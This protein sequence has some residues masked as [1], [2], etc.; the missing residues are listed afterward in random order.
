M[1]GT[2]VMDSSESGRH[3]RVMNPVKHNPGSTEALGLQYSSCSAVILSD[4]VSVLS[5]SWAIASSTSH[6]VIVTLSLLATSSHWKYYAFLSY[7]GVFKNL[8]CYICFLLILL[9]LSVWHR[10]LSDH[11][12]QCPRRALNHNELILE[13]EKERTETSHQQPFIVRTASPVKGL[14]DHL[15][16]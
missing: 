11:S 9:F 5:A 8:C 7:F 13:T 4:P 1:T 6:R 3:P 2:G 14:T 15:N 16:N 10:G 12:A